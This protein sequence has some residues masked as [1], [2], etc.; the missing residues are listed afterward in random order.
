[1][2]ARARI[3]KAELVRGWEGTP[4]QLRFMDRHDSRQQEM[5]IDEA[6]E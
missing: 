1:M 2:N 3:T 5:P 4:M 6:D